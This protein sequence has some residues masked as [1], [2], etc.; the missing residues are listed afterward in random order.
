MAATTTKTARDLTAELMFLTRALKAPSLREAA[1][2]LAER[3]R[4]EAGPISTAPSS[5][6]SKATATGSRTA[7]LAASPRPPP[8]SNDHPG[9]SLRRLLTGFCFPPDVIVLAV[10]WYLRLACPTATSWSGSP[11]AARSRPRHDLP[12][13]VAVHP[14]ARRGRPTLPACRRKPLAGRRDVPEGRR[15]GCATSIAR[16]TSSA[17]LSICSSPRRDVTA[18]YRFFEPAIG[19]TR[20]TPIKVTTDRAAAYPAVLDD[21]LP[22]RWHRTDRYANNRTECDHGRLKARLRP[23]RGPKQDRS[24]T[25]VQAWACLGAESPGNPPEASGT[26]E[27]VRLLAD[28]QHALLVANGVA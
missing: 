16:S 26:R 21:L 22:A 9:V 14:T 11:S 25:V 18:V 28:D 20:V 6:P 10:R 2:R 8:T 12:V 5:S 24:A 7:T 19:T 3:A 27:W 1:G 13:G 4:A 23:M 17:R 15:G